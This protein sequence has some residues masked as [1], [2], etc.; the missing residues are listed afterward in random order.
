MEG[1]W[2][3]GQAWLVEPGS[4]SRSDSVAHSAAAVARLV[5]VSV[6]P[7]LV[8]LTVSV[9]EFVVSLPIFM[10]QRAWTRTG[11]VQLFAFV[12]HQMFRSRNC[13]T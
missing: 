3:L 7:E 10:V 13:G 4:G 8:V 12:E 9:V 11:V 6:G 5:E 1:L 2:T